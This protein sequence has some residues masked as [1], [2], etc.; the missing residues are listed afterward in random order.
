MPGTLPDGSKPPGCPP[1]WPFGT[2]KPAPS[3][4]P[5]VVR[6]PRPRPPLADMPEAPF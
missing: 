6:I 4:Q 3:A 5:P 2:V 1:W